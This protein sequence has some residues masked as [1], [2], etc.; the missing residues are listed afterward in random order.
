MPP[1]NGLALSGELDTSGHRRYGANMHHSC[2]KRWAV[3]LVIATVWLTIA[4]TTG[5]KKEAQKKKSVLPT[6]PP[7]TWWSDSEKSI[8]TKEESLTSERVVP[9]RP[10]QACSVEQVQTTV[11][12]HREDIVRCY[13]KAVYADPTLAGRLV[14]EIHIDLMGQARFLGVTEDNLNSTDVTRCI[15]GVLK[16]LAYPIPQKNGCTILY[17]FVFSA[18]A[19]ESR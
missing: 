11:R 6:G 8:R 1:V 16:K 19:P 2:H 9:Q 14:V 12:P 4:G 15:F 18:S 10:G 17:P 13:R 7:A 3:Q 5:C